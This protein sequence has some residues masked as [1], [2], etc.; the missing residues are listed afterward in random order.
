MPTCAR[1]KA[2]F[3]QRELIAPHL[4]SPSSRV[5][6]PEADVLATT[7][8]ARRSL[9]STRWEQRHSAGRADGARHHGYGEE[10]QEGAGEE[11]GAVAVEHGDAV[12]AEGPAAPRAGLVR[13]AVIAAALDGPEQDERDVLRQLGDDT[14]HSPL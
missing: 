9:D 4:I 3:P 6:A 2:A 12:E 1:S 8:A 10:E 14:P 13:R 5:T 11:P 7:A